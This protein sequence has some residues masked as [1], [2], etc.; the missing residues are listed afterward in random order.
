[1]MW[2]DYLAATAGPGI[3]VLLYWTGIIKPAACDAWLYRA[4]FP[5]VIALLLM[6][7]FHTYRKAA[8][9][10]KSQPEQDDNQNEAK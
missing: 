5:A 9:V 1:M 6:E 2:R 10:E 7:A 3:P 4:L 8:R